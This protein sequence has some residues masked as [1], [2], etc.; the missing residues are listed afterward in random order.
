[1]KYTID[2]YVESTLNNHW[3][4]RIVGFSFVKNGIDF[5]VKY[6]VKLHS[7]YEIYTPLG[8]ISTIVVDESSIRGISF[9][10]QRNSTNS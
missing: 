4:G 1:M 2:D 10:S 7:T 9:D 6:I 5:E 8:N 3:T